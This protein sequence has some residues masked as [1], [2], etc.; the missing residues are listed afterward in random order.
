MQQGIKQGYLVLL[1]APSEEGHLVCKPGLCASRQS[2]G[3]SLLT[4][5][6][7]F[8]HQSTGVTS[9]QGT[10]PSTSAR[11]GSK[12]ISTTLCPAHGIHIARPRSSV[13]RRVSKPDN[14]RGSWAARG[15][16]CS[17]LCKAAILRQ[18]RTY[19]GQ[20]GPW[21]LAQVPSAAAYLAGSGPSHN[22]S[23]SYLAP[24]SKALQLAQP[25][26]TTP[27]ASAGH[28]CSACAGP[29]PSSW[30]P[31]CVHLSGA[32]LPVP[33]LHLAVHV[34][35]TAVQPFLAHPP[36]HQQRGP[37]GRHDP[38][39]PHGSAALHC[40]PVQPRGAG[41][42]DPGWQQELQPLHH[43]TLLRPA[44]VHDHHQLHRRLPHRERQP[45]VHEPAAPGAAHARLRGGPHLALRVSHGGRPWLCLPAQRGGPAAPAALH[46]QDIQ[47]A[48]QGCNPSSIISA[49][50]TLLGVLT[51]PSS[52][53]P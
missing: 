43:P 32:G 31:A 24:S 6:K 35:G 4:F 29:Y 44:L 33:A 10:R 18:H 49:E 9:C 52:S 51:T 45:G 39:G 50:L 2:V 46:H 14:R 42:H 22:A 40:P 53:L 19:Q 5:S 20:R 26:A 48:P 27:F 7:G 38:E 17:R 8:L 34:P 13:R 30:G 36:H 47:H 25:Q 23:T 11:T 12:P 28:T 41:G 37:A 1:N 21:A 16:L 3:H 15:L